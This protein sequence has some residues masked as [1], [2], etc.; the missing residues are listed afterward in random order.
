MMRG[1]NS[2]PATE[3]SCNN[4]D[5]TQGKLSLQHV[6]ATCP[7]NMSPQHVPATCPRNMSPSVCWPLYITVVKECKKNC[8]YLLAHF[9]I[10]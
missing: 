5:V 6:P 2:V 3:L 4:W 10:F 8:A 1:Q 9:V 7:R